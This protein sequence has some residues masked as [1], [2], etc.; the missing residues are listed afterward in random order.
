VGAYGERLAEAELLRRGWIP[1]N[2]NA[3]IRN[4]AEFDIIAQKQHRA[5]LL[6]ITACRPKS[7]VFQFSTK[8]GTKFAVEE[9]KSN[10]Y[11]ILVS[12]GVERKQDECYVVPT[13]TVRECLNAHI[14]EYLAK[15]KKTGEARI[16]NGQWALYLRPL[17]SGEERHSHGYETKWANHREN[18]AALDLVAV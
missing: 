17:K 9:L 14:K 7:R 1:S 10:D 16:D 15:R 2:A 11:T 4:A 13:K 12:M 5:I 6:R 18:W 3:S 8:K